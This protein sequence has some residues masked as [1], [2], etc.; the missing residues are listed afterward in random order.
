[1]SSRRT[2]SAS[3]GAGPRRA[4]LGKI[5]RFWDERF[6]WGALRGIGCYRADVRRSPLSVAFVLGPCPSG[7]ACLGRAFR[8]LTSAGRSERF[9]KRTRVSRLVAAAAGMGLLLT[10]VPSGAVEGQW[11]AGLGAGWSSASWRG[12]NYGGLAGGAHASYGLTDAFNLMLELGGSSHDVDARRPNL[13]LLHGVVGV[14]YTLDITRVVPYFGL[15]GGAYRASGVDLAKAETRFG[16]QG[17]LGADYYLSRT[18]A[19]GAQLQ[20]HFVTGNPTG[21]PDATVLARASYVWGW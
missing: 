14:A 9:G 10:T 13:T 11:Q 1:M 17:V 18:W 16:L 5:R 2:K 6:V 8:A 3:G 19:L 7:R 21:A 15:L 4:P 12:A 20:Y